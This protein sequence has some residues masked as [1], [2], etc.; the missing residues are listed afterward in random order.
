MDTPRRKRRHSVI[1]FTRQDGTIASSATV[2]SRQS[3]NPKQPTTPHFR[4]SL[5]AP[6]PEI[7]MHR[8]NSVDNY[9]NY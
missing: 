5:N 1:G 7:Q 2:P 4:Y 9:I 3:P 6:R 8:Q